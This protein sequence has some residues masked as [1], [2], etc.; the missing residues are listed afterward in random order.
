M[1]GNPEQGKSAGLKK[2]V[3]PL[4]KT[5]TTLTDRL[6]K[7]PSKPETVLQNNFSRLITDYESVL[8]SGA[9]DRYVLLEDVLKQG[10][11]TEKD[12]IALRQ[13]MPSAIWIDKDSKGRVIVKI[14]KE[15]RSIKS[16][17]QNVNQEQVFSKLQSSYRTA[18]QGNAGRYILLS[19]VLAK[20]E[21]T[22]KEIIE[23]R[24]KFPS[25]VWIDKDS[26]GRTLIKI[27]D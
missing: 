2:I 14:P 25:K 4:K 6:L 21:I 13:K 26:R 20:G 3:E 18:S 23:L 9:D 5:Y 17:Q 12:L 27:P 8:Q 7:R 16:E 22:E 19:E 1:V 15:A 11:L 24:Q 10:N